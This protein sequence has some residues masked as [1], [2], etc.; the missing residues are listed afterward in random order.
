MGLVNNPLWEKGGSKLWHG[1][2]IGEKIQE[3]KNNEGW[4]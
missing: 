1:R 2:K 3:E 4:K